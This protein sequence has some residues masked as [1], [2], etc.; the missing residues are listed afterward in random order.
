MYTNLI[1]YGANISNILAW[2]QD[3]ASVIKIYTQISEIENQFCLNHATHLAVVDTFYK[4]KYCGRWNFRIWEGWQR[5]VSLFMGYANLKKD[6]LHILNRV[7]KIKIIKKHWRKFAILLNFSKKST[8]R[9]DIL[10][11]VEEQEDKKNRT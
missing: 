9:N 10:Q 5:S 4:K 11:Y 8:I 1:E 3:E 7:K 6:N 2:T